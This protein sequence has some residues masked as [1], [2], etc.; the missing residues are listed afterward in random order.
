MAKVKFGAGVA[1]IRGHIGGTVFSRNSSGAY[2]R[3]KVTPVNPNTPRQ[4]DVRNSLTILSK[5]WATLSNVQRTAWAELAKAFP[6]TDVF[7]NPVPLSGIAQYQAVNNVLRN[8]GQGTID[9]PPLDLIVPE[10]TI[11]SLNLDSVTQ[12]I[13][14][15]FSPTPLPAN[16]AIYAFATATHSP[17]KSFVSNLFRFAGVT[18]A[19]VASAVLIPIPVNIQPW[20]AGA[21]ASVKFHTVD[22]TKGA[23][24]TGLIRTEVIVE[25]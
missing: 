11:I 2:M 12:Q 25:I 20:V 16:I 7:G 18:T 1:D 9:N 5:R 14:L 4:T 13:E 22:F 19:A 23:L 10:L 17:G 15:G 24:S 8:A 21:T 3:E 6:R